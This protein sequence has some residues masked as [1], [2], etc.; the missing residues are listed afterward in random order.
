MKTNFQLLFAVVISLVLLNGSTMF[1]QTETKEKQ[2]KESDK[3]QESEPKK[4]PS[5][6]SEE[7][8]PEPI[9]VKLAKDN[10]HFKASGTWNSVPPKS[11]M[12]EAELKIPRVGDDQADG[13]LTIMGAGGTIDANIV[14][15]QGQFIQPDGSKT[16]EKT[17]IEKKE[18][19]GQKV[20]LVDITGTYLDSVGGPFSGQPKVERENYRMLAAIVETT[21]NGN[22]FV[23]L[24]G[25]KATI[26]KNATH[27]KSMIESLKVAE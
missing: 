1:G 26:D 10:I 4:E 24:Y 23:K 27:F 15:W 2:T 13:R 8:A 25:P 11:R 22:Y 6:T 21:S 19:N 9:L 7:E 20:N 12:L 18:I 14:R 5:D 16:S 3:Q 17:K